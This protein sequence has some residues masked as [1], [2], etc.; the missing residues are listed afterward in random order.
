M[1]AS[2]GTPWSPQEIEDIVADYFAMLETEMA[3]GAVVKKAH[4]RALQNVID[5]S[6]GS[7]EY[8]HQNISAVLAALGLR[9]I[10]GYK[11]AV[12]YQHALFDAIEARID[13]SDIQ[14]RM[15]DVNVVR[16]APP[17]VL[18]YVPPPPMSS[19]PYTA[20]P[21]L[22]RLVRKFDPS[23]ARRKSPRTWRSG[24]SLPVS[25]RTRSASDSTATMPGT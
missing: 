20:N 21:V 8:K 17:Q 1:Q 9:Y 23:P 24:G 25:S 16:D 22:N 10:E 18:V 14:D 3:G 19:R 13:R 2:R 11:P 15:A 5:R 7:I 4:N 12:N 6:P